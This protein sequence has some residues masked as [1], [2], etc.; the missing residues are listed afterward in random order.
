M[1]PGTGGRDTILYRDAA[2]MWRTPDGM[3]VGELRVDSGGRANSRS[4]LGLGTALLSFALAS[5]DEGI[6]FTRA[7]GNTEELT[8]AQLRTAAGISGG[9]ARTQLFSGNISV[10]STSTLYRVSDSV[11]ID[12]GQLW[13][14][15]LDPTA[16][17]YAFAAQI[18]HTDTLRSLTSLGTGAATVAISGLSGNKGRYVMMMAIGGFITNSNVLDLEMETLFLARDDSYNL[19]VGLSNTTNYDPMPLIVSKIG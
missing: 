2:N 19:Y 16:A 8:R 12:A 6:E 14:I 5:D 10:T 1:G 13:E 11:T 4:Q 9:L 18:F 15:T 17:A 3:H 7:D